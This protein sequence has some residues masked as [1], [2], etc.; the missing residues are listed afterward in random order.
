MLA[1][2]Q[3]RRLGQNNNRRLLQSP[4]RSLMEALSAGFAAQSPGERF[5]NLP[6]RYPMA[7]KRRERPRRPGSGG[8]RG[9]LIPDIGIVT[10]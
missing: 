10:S 5:L 7:F 2:T 4:P 3:L 8:R 9:A 6:T 1:S